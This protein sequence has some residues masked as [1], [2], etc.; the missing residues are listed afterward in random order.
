M[1]VVLALEKE[2]IK[3]KQEL[4][5]YHDYGGYAGDVQTNKNLNVQ[6]EM[7]YVWQCQLSLSLWS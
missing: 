1:I 6:L 4:D 5:D 2:W 3:K 7:Y